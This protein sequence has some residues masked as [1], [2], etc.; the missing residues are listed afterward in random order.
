[1]RILGEVQKSKRKPKELVAFLAEKVRIDEELFG[2]LVDCLK[3]GT[4][5]QKGICAEVMEYVTKDN[6]ELAGPYLDSIIAYI[7]YDAPK[8]KW[9]TARVVANV[10]RRSPESVA[11]AIP[12]LLLN[13]EDT[14]TVVRWSAAYA[15]TEIAKHNPELSL[16][17]VPRFVKIMKK[18]RNSGVKNVYLKALKLLTKE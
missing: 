13:T 9:E 7:N 11:K 3:T 6:P 14:G 2:E 10:S 1:M 8:V 17:L 18:E 4:D 16:N 12:K 15:L 5:V